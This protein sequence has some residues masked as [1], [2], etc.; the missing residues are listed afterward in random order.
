MIAPLFSINGSSDEINTASDRTNKFP[1]ESAAASAAVNTKFKA[2]TSEFDVYKRQVVLS[3]KKA[4]ACA[5]A[6]AG[7][8]YRFLKNA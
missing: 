7:K 1:D 3:W 5:A 4:A 2:F 6:F 8:L